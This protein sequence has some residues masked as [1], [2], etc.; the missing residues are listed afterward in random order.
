MKDIV[1]HVTPCSFPEAPHLEEARCH[2]M[3]ILKQ[4]CE[5]VPMV[6]D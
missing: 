3:R 1:V 4:S 6:R 2:V 5:E